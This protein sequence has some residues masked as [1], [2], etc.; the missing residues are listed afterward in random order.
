MTQGLVRLSSGQGLGGRL[1][2]ALRCPPQLDLLA[3][4]REGW[5]PMACSL[6][7]VARSTALSWTIGRLCS[8]H[9]GDGGPMASWLAAHCKQHGIV[10][11]HRSAWLFLLH[12]LMYILA[13]FYSGDLVALG[14]LPGAAALL[15]EAG[16]PG[17][18]CHPGGMDVRF[19]QEKG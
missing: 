16:S 18:G 6:R 9:L 1:P 19:S 17:K 3:Y 2:E 7:L 4:L 14:G 11:D 13:S 10:L 5:W 8:Y 12:V 15:V